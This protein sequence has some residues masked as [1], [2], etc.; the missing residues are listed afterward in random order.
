MA[1]PEMSLKNFLSSFSLAY[2]IMDAEVCC[3]A[4]DKFKLLGLITW[5]EP[6]WGSHTFSAAVRP[7]VGGG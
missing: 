5:L 2:K 7:G 4:H 6:L 3:D 1:L